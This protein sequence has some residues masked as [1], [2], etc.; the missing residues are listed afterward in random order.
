M[1][2]YKFNETDLLLHSVIALDI[3]DMLEI[4]KI[5]IICNN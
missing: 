1:T 5:V 2:I 3:N 4:E